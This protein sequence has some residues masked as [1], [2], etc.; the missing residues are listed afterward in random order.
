MGLMAQGKI[1]PPVDSEYD[2]ADFKEAVV[3]AQTPGL[4]GKVL[5]VG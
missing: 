5:L 3:K 1:V 4:K 2:L